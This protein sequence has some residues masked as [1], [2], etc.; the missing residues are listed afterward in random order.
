MR[1]DKSVSI[2]EVLESILRGA[3]KTLGCN[4]ANLI[5]FNEFRKEVRIQVGLLLERQRELADL[6]GILGGA[7]NDFVFTF[8]QARE[9]DL[10]RAWRERSVIEVSSLVA[11]ARGAWPEDMLEQADA[12]IGDH[13]FL[14]VPAMGETNCYGVII[15]EKNGT[16]PFSPQQRELLIMYSNRI[17]EIIEND[18]RS[19]HFQDR[20]R[21]HAGK[22]RIKRLLMDG[23]GEIVSRVEAGGDGE[24]LPD[25]LLAE[26]AA[27]SRELLARG[28]DSAAALLV[29]WPKTAARSDGAG[30]FEADIALLDLP[31]GPFALCDVRRIE[32]RQDRSI[33]DHLLQIALEKSAPALLLDPEFHI[34]SCNEATRTILDYASD[35]L[36]GRDVG[37]LFQDEKEI[38]TI[39]NHQFLFVSRGHYEETT[40]LKRKNGDLVTARVEALLLADEADQV[41]GYLVLL[42]EQPSGEAAA[43]EKGIDHLMRR[44]RL[45][46][47][48]EIAGQLAHEI[49][50]PILAIGATL[51]SLQRRSG[52]GSREREIM[53]SLSNEILRLDM[54]LKDYLS[55]AAR[56]NAT[57]TKV[58]IREVIDD[59]ANLLMG[60]QK[61]GGKKIR[62]DIAADL[63]IYGDFDGLKQVFFN[64]FINAMEASPA[65]AEVFCRLKQ[66]DGE[67]VVLVEDSGCGLKS[68][69]DDC[70]SPFFSTKSNGTGLGL[71]VCRKIIEAHSGSIALENREGGGCRASVVLPLRI[72]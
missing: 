24:L 7:I 66:S 40:I 64:L 51:E 53:A 23:S 58:K 68:D 48:G 49:R 60:M 15:F 37:S 12:F 71:T 13:K 25:E 41:L 4:S 38:H 65:G 46:N 44:E 14:F 50:N 63:E 8:E 3:A 30:E 9:T 32:R 11:L 16:H 61:I 27:R 26:L 5:V 69:P 36:I 56:Q 17:G 39:L 72:S 29:Q 22:K 67:I 33:Q 45:A 52:E 70:L 6:E 31:G 43:G 62:S 34:T 10:F 59:A 19:F 35:E 42:R 1:V 18:T 54:I 21:P 28:S 57:I 47:M 20:A 55:L 2:D